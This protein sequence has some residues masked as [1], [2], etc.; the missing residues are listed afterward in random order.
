MDPVA[1]LRTLIARHA[2]DGVT[3]T[4][5]AG[6]SVMA[7]TAP[8]APLGSVA[9]PALAVV[10][11]GAKRTVVNQ[12]VFDYGA[13]QYLVVSVDLPVTAHITQAS[14]EAPFLA[15]GMALRPAVIAALLLEAGP[16]TARPSAPA[17]VAVSDA[18]PDLLDAGVRLLRL[19]DQPQSA[20]AL[21]PLYEREILWRLVTGDQGA[22]VRQIGLADSQL[23]QLGH[24]IAWI[25]RHYD[26]T[27]RIDDLAALSGMSAS[28]FHRHFRAA[29]EMTPI[30]YQKQ[31]RLQE[32]RARLIAA[33]GEVGGVGYA[34]GYRSAS[35]FSREY[36][37]LFGVPPGRDAERLRHATTQG[38]DA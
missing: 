14:P 20:R 3:P 21:A 15:F 22:A 38:L 33:P 27:V 5:L 12:R 16:G 18:T 25:R 7:A 29:T 8:T 19:L 4:A 32:A 13:A 34:V 26:Q 2:R 10:V 30:Q 23:S 24:A 37:R 17:G 11:Q 35:Q 1:E 6:V 28:A 36:R 31:V 9:V